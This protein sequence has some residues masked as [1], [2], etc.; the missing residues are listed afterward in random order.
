[1]LT[2]TPNSPSALSTEKSFLQ[3]ADEVTGLVLFLLIVGGGVV[4]PLALYAYGLLFR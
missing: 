3:R 4:A 2:Q 1:M